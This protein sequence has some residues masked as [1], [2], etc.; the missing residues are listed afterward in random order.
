MPPVV[1]EPPVLVV[2]PVL[3]KPPVESVPPV[4]VGVVPP[5]PVRPPAALPMPPEPAGSGGSVLQATKAESN[6]PARKNGAGSLKAIVGTLV[7]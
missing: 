4:G 2:P 1:T 7:E 5:D 6:D 3:G